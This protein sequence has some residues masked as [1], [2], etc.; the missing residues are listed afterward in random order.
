MSEAKLKIADHFCRAF[1]RAS[2]RSRATHELAARGSEAVPILR[3]I[4]NGEAK[5]EWGIAYRRLGMPVDC[6]LVTIK[7]LGA[8]ASPLEDLVRAE[9]AAGHPYAED[10]LRAILG[11]E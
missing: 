7:R 5:N 8:V 10:A 4:L 6:S 2:D 1:L 11:D 9:I 3:S